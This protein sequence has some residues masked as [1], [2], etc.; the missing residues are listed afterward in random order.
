MPDEPQQPNDAAPSDGGVNTSQEPTIHTRVKETS[1][2]SHRGS[3]AFDQQP[4][5]VAPEGPVDIPAAAL[6][7]QASAPASDSDGSGSGEGV[8]E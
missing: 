2:W 8:S 1:E 5:N 4:V 7:P 3:V 6:P